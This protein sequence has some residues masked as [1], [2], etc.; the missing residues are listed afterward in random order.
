[1]ASYVPL[2]PSVTPS[3]P[4]DSSAIPAAV[5]SRQ[6]VLPRRLHPLRPRE[7][8]MGPTGHPRPRARHLR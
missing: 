7:G 8:A 2:L 6:L 4:P 1:V 5:R 3:I